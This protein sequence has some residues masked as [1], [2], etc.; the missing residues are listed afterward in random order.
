MYIN[1][2][3]DSAVLYLR[4]DFYNVIFKIKQKLCIASGSASPTPPKEKFWVRTCLKEKVWNVLSFF[5]KGCRVSYLL[6]DFL[7]NFLRN[8]ALGYLLVWRF[9]IF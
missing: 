3:A 2:V 6:D 9:S 1:A 7:L 5:F 4:H 8:L